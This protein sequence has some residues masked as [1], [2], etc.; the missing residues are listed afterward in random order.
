MERNVCRAPTGKAAPAFAPPAAASERIVRPYC[1][2]RRTSPRPTAAPP[3][4]GIAGA[5]HVAVG[6]HDDG[7]HVALKALALDHGVAHLPQARHRGVL[8]AALCEAQRV[9]IVVEI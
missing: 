4:R 9:G 5:G 1:T 6:K 2:T 7:L 8:Q 3:R